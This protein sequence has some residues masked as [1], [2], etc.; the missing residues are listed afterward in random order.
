MIVVVIIAVIIAVA[1]PNILRSR[2]AANESACVANLRTIATQEFAFSRAAEVDQDGDNTGEFGWLAELAGEICPRRDPAVPNPTR[3]DPPFVSPGFATHASAGPGYAVKS[4]YC[5]RLY[6]CVSDPSA[7]NDGGDDRNT[8]GTDSS[9]GTPLDR[10]NDM[11]IINFQEMTFCC[12]AWPLEH[13]QTGQRAFAVNE[14]GSSYSTRMQN[15]TYSGSLAEMDDYSAHCSAN[16]ND[17]GSCFK[18]PFASGP[19]DPGND[20]NIWNPPG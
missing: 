13:H 18:D 10:I 8:N 17:G 7:G 5:Y 9:W 15:T 1:V 20:G 12:Q 11:H 6:L 16:M 3:T 2:M 4:G 19:D 14:I